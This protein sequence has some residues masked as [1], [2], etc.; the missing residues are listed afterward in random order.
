M[1]RIGPLDELQRIIRIL[2]MRKKLPLDFLERDI[3]SK[4]SVFFFYK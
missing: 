2:E 3:F 4:L 1:F